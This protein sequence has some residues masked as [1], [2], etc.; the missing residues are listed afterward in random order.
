MIRRTGY[1]RG[2]NMSLFYTSGKV[3]IFLTL[4]VYVL[5]GNAL[6]ADKV[7]PTFFQSFWPMDLGAPDRNPSLIG[8]VGVE[9]RSSSSFRCSTTFASS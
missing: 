5:G 9:R 4:L 3:I 1:Y 7:R 2:L 6:T 8:I